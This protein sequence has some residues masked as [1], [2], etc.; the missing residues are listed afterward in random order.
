MA[1][2]PKKK[3]VRRRKKAEART[4]SLDSGTQP[5]IAKPAT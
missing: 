2:K 3:R 4:P 1:P 5:V